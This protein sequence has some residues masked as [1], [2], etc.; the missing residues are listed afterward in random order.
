MIKVYYSKKFSKS[1]SILNAKQK[2]KLLELIVL[3]SENPNHSQIHIK[4]LT[5]EL[6]GIYSFRLTREYR[7][8]FRFTSP[9]EI[10]LLEIGHRKDIYR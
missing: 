8:L 6:S 7:V 1:V 2:S 5:G 4:S 10:Q 3:L 9:L